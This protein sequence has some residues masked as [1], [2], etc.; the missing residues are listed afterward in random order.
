MISN[1]VLLSLLNSYN[2][3]GSALKYYRAVS[4]PK[5][6]GKYLHSIV[7]KKLG[8]VRLH[9]TLTN[10][11]IPTFDIKRLQ[12]TIFSSYEVRLSFGFEAYDFLRHVLVHCPLK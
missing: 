12:P 3:F 5:Y 11:V 9:Q 1:K 6:D 7:R 2:P 8:N 10:I 4:G